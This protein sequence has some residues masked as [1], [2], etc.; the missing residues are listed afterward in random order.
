MTGRSRRG[1]ALARG[2]AGVAG[3]GVLLALT[4]WA[5]HASADP[6]APAN[7][8]L[9]LSLDGQHWSAAL[10]EPLFDPTVRWSPG[11]RGSRV[12]FVRNDGTA[13]RRLQVSVAVQGHSEPTWAVVSS[14]FDASDPI[15]PGEIR[16]VQVNASV[17]GL[18]A[19]QTMARQ[20]RVQ[21]EVQPTSEP[22]STWHA[23]WSDPD[24]LVRPAVATLG[25]LL[26]LLVLGVLHR[27]RESP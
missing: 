25:G 15:A 18:A 12:V 11:D 19:D 24:Q 5:G 14:R 17:F 27:R 10:S 4:L 3:V 9:Q 6:P 21:L 7:G 20:L 26:T 22:G 23:T 8:G 2:C 13:A 16:P 1:V